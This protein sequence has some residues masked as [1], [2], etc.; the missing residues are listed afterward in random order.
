MAK[1]EKEVTSA[2]SG[3]VLV[4]GSINTDLVV[5]VKQ[6][7]A[8][9]ETVTGQG[10]HIFGGGKG[11]NQTLASVR[12]GAT[13]A[14][15]GAVGDDDFGRQ[16]LADLQSEGV[17]CTGVAVS[18]SAPSGVALIIVESS[19]ENR[20]AYVPGA[21]QTVTAEQAN[22]AF[23]LIKPKVVLTTLELPHVALSALIESSKSFGSLVIVNAT[24]EPSQGRDLASLADVLI[25]NE[26]EACE[27]LDLPVNDHNWGELA[28]KLS[29]LGPN[30]VV[31]TLSSKGA[32]LKADKQSFSIPAPNVE[33]VDTTGAGDAYCGALAAAL[34]RGVSMEN[35]AKIGVAAGAV[36]VT[37]QGAQPSMPTLAEIER[38]TAN[39]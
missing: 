1:T 27:L 37:K 6:S 29:D 9:G 8:A 24:P 33:V 39:I 31:I 13:T 36:A 26:T 10:F 23:D 12:S 22:A 3:Q 15:L 34:A 19:G 16:R 18:A 7:P 5:N 20:I 30:S 17:D 11:A 4:A 28:T 2:R 14:I 32:V 35:A 38:L 25:V 21:S